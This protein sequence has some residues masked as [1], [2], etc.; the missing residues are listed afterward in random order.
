VIGRVL[1]LLWSNLR[2]NYRRSILTVLGV[3]VAIFVFAAL[4]A[5]ID[6]VLFPVRQVGASELLNVRAAGRANVLTSR[7]PTTYENRVARVPG[8]RAATG[9][10]D[11]IAVVG[12]EG[13]HIFVRGIDPARYRTVHDVE[14]DAAAWEEFQRDSLAALVGYRLMA[15]M[16]WAIGDEVEVAIINL[17][18]RIVGEIPAQ[19]VDLESHMLVRRQNLQVLRGAEGEVTYVLVAPE[20]GWTPA[21]LAASIDDAMSGAPIRTETATVA[22]Y[23]E[24]VVERFMGFVHYLRL[25][26]VITVVITVLGAVN[27]LAMS[28][29]ER[30]REIGV[31][32]A[33]GFP[34]GNV[35]A[36][37][38][39]E[40]TTLST[41]GGLLGLSAALLV[42][43]VGSTR[44]EGMV[45][46]G[47]TVGV[48]VALAIVIG[49]T[50][51]LIP[52]ISAARLRTIDALRVIN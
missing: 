51:G 49:L 29:R 42:F 3:G 34:P 1:P 47:S 5:A 12:E 39:M 48:G 7:L 45:I 25:M 35:L 37:V 21:A 50:A 11:E 26:E 31:L 24:A 18:A 19:G 40:S 36:V 22:G 20:E 14:V 30:T 2:R 15:R 38:V 9:V 28:I 6:S 52:G 13:I 10:L 32:K 8:V 41:L 17:R 16:G 44:S 46:T 43:G 33:I 4:G 23:A 27:A